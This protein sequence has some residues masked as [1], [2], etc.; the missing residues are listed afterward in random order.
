MQLVTL[1][2]WRPPALIILYKGAVCTHHCDIIHT[3]LLSM[4]GFLAII[5]RAHTLARA[6][7]RTHTHMYVYLFGVDPEHGAEKG[8]I[9]IDNLGVYNEVHLQKKGVRAVLRYAVLCRAVL[10][11][12]TISR[13]V[14]CGVVWCG[15]QCSAVLCGAVLHTISRVMQMLSRYML[16]SSSWFLPTLPS[17]DT[18]MDLH[19]TVLACY[20]DHIGAFRKR[21]SG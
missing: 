3:Y 16:E 13:V 14:W 10:V 18:L 8:T 15:V 4:R 6:N 17:S 2:A 5:T 11:L 19:V 21:A 20:R 9:R 12:H 1:E 7:I